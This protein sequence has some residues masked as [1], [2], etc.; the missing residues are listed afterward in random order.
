MRRN[1]IITNNSIKINNYFINNIYFKYIKKYDAVKIVKI[2]DNEE[3]FLTV[4][5]YQNSINLNNEIE[6]V[7]G[8]YKPILEKT[9]Q[10]FK[11]YSINPPYNNIT[12]KAIETFN[13][14]NTK[15]NKICDIFK[16]IINIVYN[17]S[18]KNIELKVDKIVYHYDII[19][20]LNNLI[21][22][23]NKYDINK[24]LEKYEME[25]SET[26]IKNYN[27]T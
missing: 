22:K 10:L 9:R 16:N 4:G 18:N 21:S 5:S 24:K 11:F 8:F 23:I 14:S 27:T 25:L 6:Q 7:C 17:N 19:N 20:K 3:H 13:T 15:K 12:K 26:T 1:I 2:I